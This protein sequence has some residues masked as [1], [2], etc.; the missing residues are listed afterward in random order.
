MGNE[1]ES[2]SKADENSYKL[3][4]GDMFLFYKNNNLNPDNTRESLINFL[5]IY[6]F[7]KQRAE[8]FINRFLAEIS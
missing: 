4:S 1:L 5:A 7:N 6:G 8:K 2:F 3:M